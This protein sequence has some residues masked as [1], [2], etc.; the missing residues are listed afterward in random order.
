MSLAWLVV[1]FLLSLMVTLAFANVF[2]NLATRLTE[3]LRIS[4]LIIGITVAG[5][6]TSLPELAVTLNAVM[7]REPGLAVGNIVGTN[8]A[9]IGLALAIP[10]L[11]RPVRI[12]ST[13]SQ[14]NIIILFLVTLLFLVLVAAGRFDRFWGLVFIEG[15][16]GLLWWQVRAGL[17]GRMEEDAPLFNHLSSESLKGKRWRLIGIVLSLIGVFV[18]GRFLVDSS[19][20]LARLIGVKPSLIGLTVVAIGT[21]IPELATETIAARRGQV[22]LLLGQTIGSNLYN[23][24]F[25]TGV[26]AL[27]M[28]LYFNNLVGIIFLLL[29]TSL[30]FWVVR[31]HPG[32]YVGKQWGG[33]FLGIYLA[34]LV[35]VFVTKG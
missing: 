9:N 26:G 19:L 8:I 6:G 35:L 5:L 30:L 33:I 25:I 10:F 3:E 21:S 4:P 12:G 18:G 34:Y 20:G 15:G 14:K 24:L 13:K 29:M 2:V 16:I 1:I 22:K 11:M 31:T 23:I 27:F 17:R 28:P 32:K 7:E